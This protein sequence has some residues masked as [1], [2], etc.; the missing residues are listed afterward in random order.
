MPTHLDYLAVRQHQE[1][2]ARQAERF[3]QQREALASAPA[4]PER[5]VL[6]SLFARLRLRRPNEAPASTR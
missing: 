5:R 3:R 2:L 6:S 4:A 1:Q